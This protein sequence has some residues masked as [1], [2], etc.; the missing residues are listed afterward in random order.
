VLPEKLYMGIDDVL[1]L[2]HLTLAVDHL[3]NALC[4]NCCLQE[5]A[6]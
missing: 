3:S 1:R 6:A 4:L 5:C 2:G